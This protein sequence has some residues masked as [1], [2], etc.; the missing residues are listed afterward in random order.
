MKVSFRET[1]VIGFLILLVFPTFLAIRGSIAVAFLLLVILGIYSIAKTKDY[2]PHNNRELLLY[3]AFF[4]VFLFSIAT[5]LLGNFT[6]QELKGMKRLTAYIGF[7]PIFLLI[8][9]TGLPEKSFWYGITVGAIVAGLVAIVQMYGLGYPRPIGA[10]HHIVYGNLSLTLGVISLIGIS[11]FRQK[12]RYYILLPVLAVLLSFTASILSGARG[13]WI[14]I[15]FIVA[16]I[17]MLDRQ[18]GKFRVKVFVVGIFIVTLLIAYLVPETG[19]Q[20][21]IDIAI[22]NIKDYQDKTDTGSSVGLRFEM[23]KASYYLFKE[24]PF[25]GIGI[26]KYREAVNELLHHATNLNPKIGYAGHHPHN[27]YLF[28]LVERG[29]PGLIA[30]MLTLIAPML[31]FLKNRQAS[32]TVERYS[33]VGIVIVVGYMVFGLSEA[34]TYRTV[35]LNFYLLTMALLCGAIA[36]DRQLLSSK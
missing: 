30:F 25:F 36:H 21:R 13:G 9:E 35:S 18:L 5:F 2:R 8:R 33:L 4:S 3:V 34:F 12:G 17:F 6:P 31:F 10:H 28:I 19:V 15:P 29:I 23:W 24:A 16:A 7:I 20:S 27:D 32:L 26:H 1:S 11:Y 14:A 22:E